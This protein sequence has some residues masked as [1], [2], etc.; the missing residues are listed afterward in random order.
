L[1]D[2]EG[3]V[4]DQHSDGPGG[5]DGGG[6]GDGFGG[7]EEP[8]VVEVSRDFLIGSLGRAASALYGAGDVCLEARRMVTAGAG[9]HAVADLIEKLTD[10]RDTLGGM[11]RALERLEFSEE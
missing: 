8:T 10:L 2:D 5:G 3:N 9:K 4:N 11:A 6:G 1:N 7:R